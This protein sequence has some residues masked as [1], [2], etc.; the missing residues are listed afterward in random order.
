MVT[1]LRDEIA[2]CIRG[3]IQARGR[4]LLALSGGKTPLPLYA[5]LAAMELDWN[6]V[7]FALVDE[8]WVETGDP[9][10]NEYQLRGALGPA[11]AA[12]AVFL[13]MKNAA[14]R[15][16]EG[17]AR[18]ERAYRELPL[19]F[20]LLLLGMGEDGHIASLFPAAEGVDRAL[21]PAENA[22]CRAITARPGK[23]TGGLVERMSL[24]RA[25]LLGARRIDLMLAGEQKLLVLERA[26][27]GTDPLEMPVRAVVQ[28]H[29]VPLLAWW[30]P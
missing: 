3:A 14:L 15:A 18:C 29:D 4:A 2:A 9:A 26:L 1:H 13:G 20:D 25:G 5:A 21:D 23:A 17:Q 6:H 30:A 16:L 7:T 8:R 19:P 27:G 28:Q 10:S 12:G 11:L 22:L 24:T